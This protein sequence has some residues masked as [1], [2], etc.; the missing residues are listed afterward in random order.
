MKLSN[1]VV[2]YCITLLTFWLDIANADTT[3]SF[4]CHKATTQTEHTLCDN[5]DL[6]RLDQQLTGLWR[7]TL[8]SFSE[9]RQV[10]E[11]RADQKQWLVT[12]NSCGSDKECIRMKYIERFKKL[13]GED[14]T[15]PAAGLYDAD[16]VGRFALYPLDTEYLVS[17]ET[18]EPKAGAWTCEISGRA[19]LNSNVLFVTVGKFNF[20]ARLSYV[21]TLVIDSGKDLIPITEGSCGLNGSVSFT[22]LR[23][24]S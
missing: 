13:S 23:S 3:P 6:A 5:P 19:K 22:Y 17:I 2:F 12:L 7:E 9:E 14:V 15:A 4:D 20:T 21:N 1:T 8:G 16:K 10:T 24:K 18:A 11:I